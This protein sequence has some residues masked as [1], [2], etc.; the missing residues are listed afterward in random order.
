MVCIYDIEIYPNF[1]CST[2]K[3]IKDE[4]IRQ[5]VISDTI[6][7]LYIQ[8]DFVKSCEYL[9][10]YNN[11]NFDDRLLLFCR[12]NEYKIKKYKAK[13]IHEFTQK[14]ING[15]END[16]ELIKLRKLHK[17]WISID[18]MKLIAGDKRA[19]S[20][21]QLGIYL[22]HNLVQDLPYSP[23]TVLTEEEQDVVLKY[24]I[25]DIII[26]E[27]AYNFLKKEILARIEIGNLYD[28]NVIDASNSR[29]GD[30]IVSKFYSDYSGL[31]YYE[32]R[33]NKTDRKVVDFS[34]IISNKIKFK[35]KNLVDLYN[36]LKNTKFE[37][38][39]SKLKESVIL[40]GL[41]YN[42][43]LGGLHTED[44]G[45]VFESTD[46]LKYYDV[47]V[48]S[49]YPRIIINEQISPKHILKN[50][51]LLTVQVLYD[52]R[53]KNKGVNDTK[54]YAMKIALNSIYGKF[55]F[56]YGWLKDTKCTYQTTINGQLYLLMLIEDLLL[57]NFK[58]IS[59][60][61]DGIVTEV[62]IER[63]EDYKTICKD[64]SKNNDFLI[65]F[66]EYSKYIRKDV[67]NYISITTSG[68][69]KEKGDFIRE[70]DFNHSFMMPIVP[71]TLYKYFIEKQD[72]MTVLLNH[73]DIYDFCMSIKTG[74]QFKNKMLYI[75]DNQLKTE[76]IQKTI[77]Y[78]VSNTGVSLIKQ[79]KEKN[80][81]VS[82]AK[83]QYVTIF[84]EYFHKDNFND[85]NINYK[86]YYDEVYKIINAVYNKG[87]LELEL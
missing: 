37:I 34:D 15:L 17:T 23:Y 66:T 14:I 53:L 7:D 32:Y 10:G 81:R 68:K 52:E 38:G 86:F 20:L 2:F 64:W 44:K 56:D 9:I 11:K 70:I 40:N 13:I 5:F 71:I 1:Y 65:E 80:K 76:D 50:E 45:G 59:A 63:T 4:I 61:T 41:R 33:N 35:T 84:N 57:N 21:K 60:N 78:Y 82:M 43:G 83:K 58:V 24:N 54:A 67:N 48:N 6:N 74:W 25:N 46:I 8:N 69:I 49:F 26:T 42:I 55:N 28:I 19:I 36:R 77:R 18:L 47:D 16:E 72:V 87:Q 39:I 29:L 79:Y 62:P 3:D 30:I 75:E 22:K 27:K 85:Y 51:F 73:R 12:E 31:S